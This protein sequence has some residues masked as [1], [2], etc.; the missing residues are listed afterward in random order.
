MSLNT[1]K[2]TSS[3]ASYTA[4]LLKNGNIT[5]I[6]G[7]STSDY[8]NMNE[9]QIFDT[10]SLIWYNIIA[11]GGDS[12]GNPPIVTLSSTSGSEWS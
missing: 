1:F 6:G 11:V 12:I 4:T 2:I 8:I 7:R 10:N 3:R 5:Y 9:I